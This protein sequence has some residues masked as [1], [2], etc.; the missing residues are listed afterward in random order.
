MLRMLLASAAI[1][2]GTGVVAFAQT[3]ASQLQGQLSAPYGAGP[4]ANK[5]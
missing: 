2:G 3:P 4:A 5:Q 1:V